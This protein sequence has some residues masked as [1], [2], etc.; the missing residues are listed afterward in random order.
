LNIKKGSIIPTKITYNLL[1]NAM[2]ES[3]NDT[4]LID[5]FPRNKENL[6]G[7]NIQMD[8]NAILKCV[9]FFESP[10]EVQKKII[11][12][13]KKLKMYYFF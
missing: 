10:D 13:Y 4:F 8:S 3:C 9:L 7:W 2:N 11:I 1:K 6:D 5:G 12:Y